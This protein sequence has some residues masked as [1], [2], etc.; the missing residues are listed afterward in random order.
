MLSKDN[1]YALENRWCT[2]TR[3]LG[4]LARQHARAHDPTRP[5]TA[6][7]DP[8][9]EGPEPAEPG[10][11]PSRLA[12]GSAV[13]APARTETTLSR[14]A[15]RSLAQRPHGKGSLVTSRSSPYPPRLR[16]RFLP[17]PLYLHPPPSPQHQAPQNQ[18]LAALPPSRSR[19]PPPPHGGPRPD[20]LQPP[21]PP[22][23]APDRPRTQGHS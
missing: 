16:L 9:P 10:A 17:V 11:P 2:W 18:T 1:A 4:A 21:R 15:G 6:E 20:E 14:G 12:P 22:P 7:W 5:N 19:R 8:A 13:P 23:L 3:E